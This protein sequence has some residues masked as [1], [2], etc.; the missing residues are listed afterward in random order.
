MRFSL[1]APAIAAFA[2][3]GSRAIQLSSLE[4]FDMMSELDAFSTPPTAG[5]LTP[6]PAPAPTAGLPAPPAPPAP[7]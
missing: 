2:I 6:A 4:P 3:A 5:N 7:A 1:F